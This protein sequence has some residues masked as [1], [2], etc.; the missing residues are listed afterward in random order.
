MLTRPLVPL[1]F[2]QELARTWSCVSHE[3]CLNYNSFEAVTAT[4]FYCTF[5]AVCY[6][7]V[8][9]WGL[10][11]ALVVTLLKVDLLSCFLTVSNT[12]QFW[13]KSGNA[14]PQELA[15]DGYNEAEAI[16]R[17]KEL[18]RQIALIIGECFEAVSGELTFF[19]LPNCFEL[20][21]FDVMGMF[22]AC[23][24]TC[25]LSQLSLLPNGCFTLQLIKTGTAGC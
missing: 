23:A 6:W 11:D 8:S 4:A 21:G 10:N 1:I 19:T 25:L 2:V 9:T 24:T 14:W 15:Q 13:I 3:S 17:T 16:C 22:M 18:T 12:L 20:F 7:N 5:F